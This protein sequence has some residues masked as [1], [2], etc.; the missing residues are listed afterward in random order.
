VGEGSF[1]LGVKWTGMRLSIQLLLV[2]RLRVHMQ[3]IYV[4][5]G[6]VVSIVLY[7]E[8]NPKLRN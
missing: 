3:C 5:C 1:M 4:N 8:E 7:L 6:R 2:P